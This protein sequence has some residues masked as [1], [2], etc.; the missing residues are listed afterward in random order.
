MPIRGPFQ[1]TVLVGL[2]AVALAGCGKPTPPNLLLISL[3]TVRRDHLPIYGYRRDTAPALSELANRGVVFEDAFAQDTN[4]GPSHASMM[5]GLYPHQHGARWNGQPL[6][7]SPATLAEILGAAGYQTGG[8]VSSLT[9]TSEVAGLARGFSHFDDALDG[10]DRRD[11]SATCLRAARWLAGLDSRKP[12]FLFLHLYDAHGPYVPKGYY[13]ARFARPVSG[14]ELDA[15]R[16]PPYQRVQDGEGRALRRLNGFVDR[17]DGMIRYL[18]VLV[19]ILLRELDLS[20]TIVV[21]VSD[22]GETLGERYHPLDHGGQLFDEQI[23]IPFFIAGPGVG[24]GRVSGLVESIDLLPTLLQLAGVAPPASL[25]ISGRSLLAMMRG[26]AG[27]ARQA[28]FSSARALSERHADRDYELDADRRIFSAR[29]NQLK[30][31]VYPGTEGDYV[32]LYDLRADS[33][34]RRNVALTSP[35]DVEAQRAI[36]GSWLKLG[37]QSAPPGIPPAIRER[38]EALGYVGS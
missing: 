16:I 1:A 31:I 11:G 33:D 38:L 12:F 3:D 25:S 27:P 24:Q 23:R 30:L 20:R 28:V 18:D 22:H 37:D 29:S 8:F 34:E 2:A 4:T 35:V 13:L 14:P 15:D 5:T 36:L 17:Y 32:E 21:V 9:M 10:E 7:S 19:A 26:E 6:P